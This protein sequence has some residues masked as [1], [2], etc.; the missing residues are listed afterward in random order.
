MTCREP[1]SRP[2]NVD[3]F[4]ID[5]PLNQLSQL[6]WE[7]LCDGCA[8]CCLHKLENDKTGDIHCTAL[9]CQLLDI[10]SC[11]CLEYS[12][13]RTYVPAC[14]SLTVEDI[15]KMT[16]LPDSCAYRL[17]YEG[18]LLPEWHPLVSGRRES[19]HEMGVSVR[20]F[21]LPETAVPE[22][23]WQTYVIHRRQKSPGDS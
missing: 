8:Q 6:E 2:K 4:W 9:A 19:V 5:K 13:R 3:C 15:P 10:D 14:I 23:Q 20:G 16:W 12:N 21:A 18:K 11:Q 1:P 22:D 17:L 7:S